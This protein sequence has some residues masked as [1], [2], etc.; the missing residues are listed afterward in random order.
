MI[1]DEECTQILTN[2][3]TATLAFNS[4]ITGV[5]PN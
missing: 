2:S 1:Y 3:I 4:A 5:D